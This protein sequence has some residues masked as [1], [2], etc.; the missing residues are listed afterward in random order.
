MP[1]LSH[2]AP[3]RQGWGSKAKDLVAS[4]RREWASEP[5]WGI[6]HT[7][8]SEAGLLQPDMRGMSALELGCGTAY[9]SAWMQRRGAWVTGLDPTPEQLAT[10]QL[11]QSEHG[12]S[13]ALVEGIGESLPF[14]DASFDLAI[15]EYG[16]ALWADPALWV[17]ECARVLRPGGQLVFLTNSPLLMLCIPDCEA[18]GLSTNE[19]RRP[20]FSLGRMTW[21]DTPEIEFHLTHSGWVRLLGECGFTVERLLELQ[22]PADA[23]SGYPW[24]DADWAHAWPTED[25]WCARKA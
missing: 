21:P 11:L 6:W 20:Y 13:F 22:A 8:E 14:R 2:I 25:V 3:N 17:Q 9:V 12:E 19:L 23:T 16:A 1:D 15:S 24:V 5:T 18:D 10:A 4:G 7:P